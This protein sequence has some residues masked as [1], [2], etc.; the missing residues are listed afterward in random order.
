MVFKTSDEAIGFLSQFLRAHLPFRDTDSGM[1]VWD[2]RQIITEWFGEEIPF[3]Q[4]YEDF[5]MDKDVIMV[6]RE[7]GAS[8]Y[9]IW[10]VAPFE[11][12][13]SGDRGCERAGERGGVV[14]C[15]L[16]DIG[17]IKTYRFETRWR[18]P[19]NFW[20]GMNDGFGKEML[21]YSLRDTNTKTRTLNFSRR[22][23]Q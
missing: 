10:L 16:G 3:M 23:F 6:K 2:E 8:N 14:Y 19:Y 21:Y 22:G 20:G 5:A 4:R 17:N 1:L 9:N 13:R 18:N 15:S 11:G 7:K 12:Y